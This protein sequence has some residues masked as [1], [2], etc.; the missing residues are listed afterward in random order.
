MK[1]RVYVIIYIAPLRVEI[2]FGLLMP[3]LQDANISQWTNIK[4]FFHK[5]KN[6]HCTIFPYLLFFTNF[7]D[8][9]SWKSYKIMD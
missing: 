6:N 9:V 3:N 7:D 8:E 2:L 4:I 1:V 5:L